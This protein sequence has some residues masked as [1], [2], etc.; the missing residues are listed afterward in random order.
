MTQDIP[1]RITYRD[2]NPNPVQS[3]YGARYL[4]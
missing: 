1:G 3:G 4:W 2:G